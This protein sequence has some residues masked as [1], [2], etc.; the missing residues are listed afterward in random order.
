MDVSFSSTIF[1][2]QE[3]KIIFDGT[4]LELNSPAVIENGT[5]LVPL[6]NV[7]EAFG[8]EPLGMEVLVGY[9]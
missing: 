4:Q 1:G 8:V 3:I 9:C 7:F 5:T 6:R 2:A